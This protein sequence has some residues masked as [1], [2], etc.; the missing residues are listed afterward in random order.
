MLLHNGNSDCPTLSPNCDW[1]HIATLVLGG[2]EYFS[3]MRV[4]VQPE[5]GPPILVEVKVKVEDEGN[6]EWPVE[7][8]EG[9]C[10][11]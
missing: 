1:T 9:E 3:G 11:R 2:Y 4:W 10:Q 7:E 6:F 5:G 8:R